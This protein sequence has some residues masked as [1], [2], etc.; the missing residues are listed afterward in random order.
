MSTQQQGD[1]PLIRILHL[2][3]CF[4]PQPTWAHEGLEE[5]YISLAET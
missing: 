1:S 2:K 3:A 5:V 4:F